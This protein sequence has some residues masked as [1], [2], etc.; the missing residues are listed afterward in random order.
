M[1]QQTTAGPERLTASTN[2][3]DVQ[4]HDFAPNCIW[5]FKINS[6]EQLNERLLQLIENE[7][8]ATPDT[9]QCAGREMWQS[10]RQVGED[11]PVKELFEQIYQVAH[12]VAEFLRWDIANLAP[13][14]KVC[15]ANVH[16]PGSYHT[17]HI[18]PATTHLSGV[19][20]IQAPENCGDIVFHDLPR[21]LGLWGAAPKPLE[22]TYHNA[23]SFPVRPEDGL[24]VLFPG[25]VMHEVAT[26]RS[27]G[28]RVGI[29]FNINF[30]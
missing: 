30:E 5:T 28:D 21:F 9:R 14:L 11:P 20:Y 10:Q 24:C 22:L 27:E 18:H 25:Y 6:Y 23:S 19:Y 12:Q 1:S 8:R 16:P 17:R 7:R 15:W 26:N 13:V 29:A 2:A 3:I 4:R